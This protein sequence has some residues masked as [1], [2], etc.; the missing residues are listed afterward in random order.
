MEVVDEE[1][2]HDT[3][4]DLPTSL[5]S[6]TKCGLQGLE[7]ELST[8]HFAGGGTTNAVTTASSPSNI[9]SSGRSSHPNFT[10]YL[11]AQRR[12]SSRRQPLNQPAE[13]ETA[14]SAVGSDTNNGVG[15]DDN[16]SDN[17]ASNM[18]SVA[19]KKSALQKQKTLRAL[20]TLGRRGSAANLTGGGEQNAIMRDDIFEEMETIDEDGHFVNGHDHLLPWY[21]PPIQRQR[22]GEDQIVSVVVCVL[23][24]IILNWRSIIC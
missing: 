6:P 19:T 16:N 1:E 23:D 24:C 21:S 17:Y 4:S 2:G 10:D 18:A 11:Q 8:R 9:N 12:L 15:R 5:P 22:W 20:E 13:V 7:R 14:V 3:L